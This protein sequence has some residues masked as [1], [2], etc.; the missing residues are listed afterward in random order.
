MSMC[1]RFH[2]EMN[3]NEVSVVS[4]PAVVK[5]KEHRQNCV[6]LMLVCVKKEGCFCYGGI[7]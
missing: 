6:Y 2:V 1:H 4:S 7:D 3:K 5:Q